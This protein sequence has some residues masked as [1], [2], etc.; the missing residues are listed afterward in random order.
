MIISHHH[1]F[2]FIKTSK[3]AGT[4]I[5]WLLSMALK[6]GDCLT[7]IP[8]EKER[9]SLIKTSKLVYLD[10]T[11]GIRSH[12]PLSSAHLHYPESK[13]YYSFAVLRNPYTRTVSGFRYRKRDKILEILKKEKDQKTQGRLIREQFNQYIRGKQ[14]LAMLNKGLRN[15]TYVDTNDNIQS[16]DH[17]IR[18]ESLEASLTKTIN[19]LGLDINIL[20]MPRLKSDTPK[21][22]S[23]IKLWTQE[24]R[25][26]IRGMFAWELMHLDYEEPEPFQS[27]R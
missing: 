26:L 1:K 15:L 13:D 17:I 22:P 23:Y 19:R 25:R 8:E 2:V 10:D 16:I 18:F 14:M 3:T 27:K 4:S 7:R 11:H 24:N 21:I 20:D 5:E 9:S 12:S 6:D